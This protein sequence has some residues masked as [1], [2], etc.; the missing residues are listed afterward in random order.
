M[1]SEEKK[2]GKDASKGKTKPIKIIS[3]EKAAMVLI[4]G[5]IVILAVTAFLY[6]ELSNHIFG[7]TEKSFELFG[8]IGEYIGG[9]VG[10]FWALAGVILFYEALRFQR[11]ELELQ[12][13][14]LKY[15]RSEIMEQ[16]RQYIIQN[17]VLLTRKL[18]TTF[19]QLLSLHNEIVSSISISSA[20]FRKYSHNGDKTAKG[21]YC[22]HFYYERFGKIVRDNF[23]L[24]GVAASDKEGLEDV[25]KESYRHL[26]QKFQEDLGHYFRNLFNLLT[27]VH[28]SKLHNKK[29]YINLIRSQLSNY[30]LLLLFY[31]SLSDYGVRLKPLLEK[32]SFFWQFPESELLDKRHMDIFN[33]QA[34]KEETEFEVDDGPFEEAQRKEEPPKP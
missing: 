24:T 8:S 30:E 5:G 22:F 15:Q 12:R 34:F 2:Q 18:E 9:V 27:F 28:K 6:I 26:F 33:P 4:W 25:L 16:T 23:D 17:Q 3:F 20:E 10:S 13:A 21:R 32:Y 29:F 19:F 1:K 31:H 7:I 14:E 11:D